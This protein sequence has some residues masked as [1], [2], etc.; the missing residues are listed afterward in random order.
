M[1]IVFLNNT[2]FVLIIE[3]NVYNPII[4]YKNSTFFIFYLLKK[5]N[6]INKVS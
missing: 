6:I 1:K 2:I 4:N 5:P 3:Y